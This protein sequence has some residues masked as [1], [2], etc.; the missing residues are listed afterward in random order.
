MN[1]EN[2]SKGRPKNIHTPIKY[3]TEE[4]KKDAIRR[5]RARYMVNK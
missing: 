4:E 5:L 2:K 3:F 1:S